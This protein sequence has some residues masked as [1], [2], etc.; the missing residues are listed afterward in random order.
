MPLEQQRAKHLITI[1]W[2]VSFVCFASAFNRREAAM[3]TVIDGSTT[4]QSYATAGPCGISSRRN[5]RL[6][7]NTSAANSP[8]DESQRGF[9]IHTSVTFPTGGVGANSS[10]VA[11]YPVMLFLNGFQARYVS[12]QI[13]YPHLADTE[14]RT[15]R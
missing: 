3:A 15:G 13:S 2:T 7:G 11:P 12:H 4:H 14:R 9:T 1:L 6:D 8:A 10:R 5:I